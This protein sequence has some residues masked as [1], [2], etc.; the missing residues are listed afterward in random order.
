MA[1]VF[2]QFDEKS[3]NIKNVFDQ[4]DQQTKTSDDVFSQIPSS[5]KSRPGTYANQV[6]EKPVQSSINTRPVTDVA[7]RALVA[8]TLGAPVDIAT[9]L[10]RP[11]GY[12]EEKPFMGSE[13]IGQKMQEAG[14]V[15]PTR[16]PLAELATGLA[17]S[18]LTGS[19][20]LARYGI[21][22][23]GELIN[24]ARGKPAAAEA[25]RV[26]QAGFAEL[27]PGIA[28]T[29]QELAD[30]ERQR[31]FT[32]RALGQIR[33]QP[34]VSQQRQENQRKQIAAFQAQQRQT[35][36]NTGQPYTPKQL[37][38]LQA[39]ELRKPISEQVAAKNVAEQER[40][41]RAEESVKQAKE[42][43]SAAKSAVDQLEQRLLSQPG[44]SAEQFGSELRQATQKLER[45]LV[46]TRAEGSGFSNVLEKY[47]DQPVVNTN[48]LVSSI[49][50]LKE[51]TRN[52]NV[53]RLLDQV[54]YLAGTEGA[55]GKVINQLSLRNADSL[56][57]Y[58]SKDIFQT[59]E[60][61]MLAAN[62]EVLNVLKQLRG[63]LIKQTPDDYKQALGAFRTL[64]RP[65]DI[66]ERNGALARVIDVDPLSTAEKLTE[67]QVTG[68]IVRK[69]Q[70][71][72]PVFTRLLEISPNLRESGRLYFTQNLFGKEAVPTEASLRTWLLAN[73]RPLRQL[74]LYDEF[75]NIR[76]ARETAQRAV[77]DAKGQLDV[78]K[79]V[80]GEAKAAREASGSMFK[81]SET[82]LEDVLGTIE[83]PGDLAKRAAAA[84][85]NAFVQK[86]NQQLGAAA[87]KREVIETLRE[88]ESNLI[89]ATKPQQ[90]ATEMRVLAKQL[91]DRNLINEEVRDVMMRQADELSKAADAQKKALIIIAKVTTAL[92]LG[93]AGYFAQQALTGGGNAP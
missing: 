4:F 30:I 62:K 75:K 16:R 6:S 35:M 82:R 2:D 56:R 78:A 13:Y 3:S 64:S 50:N 80:A 7:N 38:A 74:G 87:N 8:G 53:I 91:K 77:N 43:F 46:A 28:K 68:E 39:A 33:Q 88:A 20:G 73:E 22:K 55:D 52:P 51:Q 71:G 9:M 31:G 32:E 47:G 90:V 36:A 44:I 57:K 59:E 69:A 66:V 17:P 58:L 12:K 93:T 92:G 29:E 21:G 18:I 89:R 81:R 27:Q 63:D 49:E 37:Q 19:A 26:R 54:K 10:M 40:L 67:A 79:T 65:L 84:P 24:T 14:M 5:G 76:T 1:N 86:L 25:E 42:Q 83:K 34:I 70:Q 41:A 11:F 23:A 48:R 85:E 61:R 60:G 15:T 45:N 72:N